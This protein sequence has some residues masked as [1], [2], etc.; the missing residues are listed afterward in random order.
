MVSN[1]KA[2]YRFGLLESP[3]TSYL[4]RSSFNET[5]ATFENTIRGATYDRTQATFNADGSLL[6]NA[7]KTNPV[8]NN[9]FSPFVNTGTKLKYG[10]GRPN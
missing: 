5:R 8:A 7:V 6:S 3:E 9:T 10:K 4:S 1:I 2:K